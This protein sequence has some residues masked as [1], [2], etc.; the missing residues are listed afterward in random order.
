MITGHIKF[1]PGF[2]W[3][4]S[5]C[6]FF[7]FSSNNNTSYLY[8]GVC[9]H[10]AYEIFISEKFIKCG[11]NHSLKSRGSSS[12]EHTNYS[13]WGEVRQN[14]YCSVLA[15]C[16]G[17]SQALCPDSRHLWHCMMNKICKASLRDFQ[18][19]REVSSTFRW[20]SFRKKL[21]ALNSAINPLR[22]AG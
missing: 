13:F 18:L 16:P 10:S 4:W 7:S 19:R 12:S 11:W 5:L 6:H 9:F 14:L 2:Q 22:K 1:F 20:L 8:L 3:K 17:K 15:H 21:N